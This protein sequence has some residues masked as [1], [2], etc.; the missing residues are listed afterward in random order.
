MPLYAVSDKWEYMACPNQSGVRLG[1]KYYFNAYGMRSDEVNPHKK[2]ILGLGDSVIYGGVQT[3]QDSLATSLFTAE[4]GMQMLN[5]SAGSWGPD[6]C[7]AYLK[8]YGLFDAKGIFLLVSSHDAHDNMDFMPVVGVHPSYPDK[9]YPCAIAE[10][11]CRYIYP[12]YIKPFFDKGNHRELDPDQKVLAGIDIHKNGKVFNPGFAQL[13]VM[14]DSAKIP[15]VVYLHA[16]QE[17]NAAKKYNE[18]GDEIINWCKANHVRL[19]EDIH[20]LTKADYRDG[21][22]INAKGQRIVADVMEKEF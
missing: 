20:L 5:I 3:D 8:Q 7:A 11:L 10:V 1:N 16:D 22:H 2:H 19:V 15:F 13:K 17:E 6:N 21:I 9:Q 12:R 4:T 14:A 18:Q